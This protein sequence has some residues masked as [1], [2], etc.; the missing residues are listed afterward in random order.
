MF[1]QKFIRPILFKIDPERIHHFVIAILSLLS[2]AK[3]FYFLIRNFLNVSDSSLFIKIGQLNFSNPVGLAAGFDKNVSA[4]LAYP[5]L[6]FGFAEL[7]SITYSAQSGNAKPRLWRLPKDMGLIVYYGLANVGAQVVAKKMHNLK[8]HPIP[9]GVSLAPTSGLKIDQMSDDYLRSFEIVHPHADYIT[10]NVSC[11]NVASCDLFAQVSFIK[12]LTEKVNILKKKINSN[13]DVFLKI[14]P[15]MSMEQYDDI[16]D[17]CLQNNIVAI[18]VT[19]LIKNRSTVK[20][21]SSA[22]ELNHPGGISGDLLKDKSTAIIKYIYRRA[23]GR[24][25]IIGVGGIFTAD[26]A[27]E[28]IKAGASAVQLITGFIYNG[29]AAIYDINSW[30]IKLLKNDNLKNI[31]E[32]VGKDSI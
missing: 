26:D 4:P 1:Y 8:K 19:N 24:L 12:E 6:G 20:A 23:A 5:M 7:G 16:V 11:P 18:I 21:T 30:L 3:P 22:E 31:S 29:P 27:Y 9:L 13:V 10:L 2:R 32:A 28:K 17:I 25:K 14:G 15:D